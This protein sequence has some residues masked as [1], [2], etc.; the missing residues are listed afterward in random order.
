M[1]NSGSVSKKPDKQAPCDFLDMLRRDGVLRHADATL[2]PLTDGVSSDIFRIDD[3]EDTF[4]V[5]RALAKLRVKDDWTA[6]IARNRY[7]Y[8]YIEYVSRF[9]PHAVPLLRTKDA[10]R[11]YFAMEFLG[12]EFASWKQLLLRGEAR[13]D[14]ALLAAN[15]LGR[16]HGRS[17][18]DP[19]A[20]RQFDTTA[21]FT[22][23]RIDPYLLTTGKRHP[24][25]RAQFEAEAER[26][27][28]TRQCLVHG[29]FSPKNIMISPSRMVLLDCEVA[30]YGD[31]AFDLAFLMTHLLLK[32]LYH[33]PR[34][35]GMRE[36]CGGFWE[37][38]IE[39]AGS[40]VESATL[41]PRVARLLL[42]V[43]LA[44]VDGKS[45][46]EYLN[47]AQ[48]ERVRQFTRSKLLAERFNLSS[49]I[50]E[51][52]ANLDERKVQL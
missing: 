8:L 9:L 6:D 39:V 35:I 31:P 34:Q 41:Q 37:R 2:T 7:E 3:G 38:Y 21:N 19:D 36:M 42:M 15:V 46:V 22:Q 11:G 40:A 48:R 52:F 33:A 1:S 51:W 29:D 10:H 26:L 16:I 44:R 23:L 50:F 25:L 13:M 12:P 17:A 14:H 45:P 30:W 47:D 24:D 5:K 32:G 4:V 28:S 43:L 20:Q 18:G 27:A 49:I